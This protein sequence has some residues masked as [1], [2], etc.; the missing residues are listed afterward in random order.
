M[1]QM[2]EQRVI[3]AL[4][5]YTGGLTVTDQEIITAESRLRDRLEPPSPR[6]RLVILA[7]AVAAVLVVGF[8]LSRAIDWDQ[9]SAQPVDT[10]SSP[11]DSL[12]ETL[13]ADAYDLGVTDFT[14]GTQ[15]TAQDMAGFWLLREPY[16][17]LMFVDADGDWL[18]GGAP[19]DPGVFG[20]STLVADTW[21]RRHDERSQC[22]NDNVGSGLF[23]SWR[24]A[25]A[26]DG[27]LR[28]EQTGGEPTCTP[29]DSREVWDRVTPGLPVADYLLAA[30]QEADWQAAPRSFGW[31]GLYVAP[32]TGHVLEARDDETYRYYDSLTDASLVA[33]DRGELFADGERSSGSCAGGEF[34]GTVEVAQLPGVTGYVGSYDAVRFDTKSHSCDSG[35]TAQDVWVNVR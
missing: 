13:Q 16:V 34:A 3:D 18:M 26:A 1:T 20:P 2:D 6:R 31:Q 12:K 29:A 10:P 33:A 7:A 14:A 30:T 9:E 32:A 22:G 25:V 4:R 23:Q 24:A 27:S 8:F 17:G 5:A 35:I 28:L 15:P 19:T 21:T 11:A